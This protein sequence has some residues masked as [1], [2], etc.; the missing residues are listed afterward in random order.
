[1]SG[2][3]TK[4]V[5]RVEVADE[6]GDAFPPG[7]TTKG[8]LVEA[9]RHRRVRPQVVGLLESLPERRYRHLRELWEQLPR[10]PIE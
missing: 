8:E 2:R 4:E 6:V 9:A 7:G 5:T 3:S 10:V 1:M